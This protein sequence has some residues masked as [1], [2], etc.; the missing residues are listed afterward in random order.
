LRRGHDRGDT[1][2][3]EHRVER[4]SELGVAVSDEMGEA[5]PGGFDIGGE[6]PGRLGGAGGG[7]VPGDA[8]QVNAAGGVLDDERD[9]EPG[10]GECAVDVKEV[11]GQQ[12]V[13][14][15]SQ[16]CAPGVV[17]VPWWRD[18]VGAQDLADRGR[19]ASSANTPPSRSLRHR[20]QARCVHTDSLRE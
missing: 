1:D 11:R 20:R 15:G 5:V 4:G 17:A 12:G 16:E 7:R 8:E 18:P 19:G 6:V 9:V 10:E 3:G 14:L 13:G 2:R